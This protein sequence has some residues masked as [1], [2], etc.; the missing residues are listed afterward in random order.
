MNRL[1]E[2]RAA[3]SFDADVAECTQGHAAAGVKHV[4]Q[5]FG[6]PVP[7]LVLDHPEQ[8][9]LNRLELEM[10]SIAD[11]TSALGPFGAATLERLGHQASTFGKRLMGA[12]RDFA[13]RHS[14]CVP[15]DD[16][17][18]ICDIN[19]GLIITSLNLSRFVNRIKLRMER[20]TE[21][22]KR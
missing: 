7:E 12:G 5:T 10:S 9:R 21:N 2:H 14:T 3:A 8:V 19:L 17:T 22:V 1:N 15:S 4:Q 18:A 16:M 13:D 6:G 11:S 20:T